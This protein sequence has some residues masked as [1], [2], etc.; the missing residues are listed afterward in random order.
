MWIYIFSDTLN[1]IKEMMNPLKRIK[2]FYRNEQFIRSRK[3]IYNNRSQQR[4][5]VDNDIV[6]L[7]CEV[8]FKSFLEKAFS[9]YF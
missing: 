2:S 1:N 8:A 7:F 4:R 9:P 5:R 3:S 6:I